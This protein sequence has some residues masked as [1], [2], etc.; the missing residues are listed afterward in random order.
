MLYNNFG[1]DYFDCGSDT[2]Y[3]LANVYVV[4][5][6]ENSREPAVTGMKKILNAN[7]TKGFQK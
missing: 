2:G 6:N 3:A 4:N 5:A 1:G 7:E